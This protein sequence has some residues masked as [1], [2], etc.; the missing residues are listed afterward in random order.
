MS[1]ELELKLL[2]E[3][4]LLREE[5]NKLKGIT[6]S[7]IPHYQYSKLNFKILE[8]IIDIKQNFLNETKFND[9]FNTKHE[10]KE[11]DI[12]FLDKL[13]NKNKLLLDNY[14][15]E[16]LKANFIIPLLNKVDFLLID[17]EIRAFYEEKLFYETDKFTLGG[18]TDFLVSKGLKY[19]KKPYFFIQEFT[20]TPKPPL[21]EKGEGTY[22]NRSDS[23]MKND[24]P[25]PQ[26]LAEMVSAI[27]LNSW[28]SIKGAY[29]IGANWNFVI[30]EKVNKNKYQYFIS[31]KFDSMK[32]EDLVNIYQYLISI[33]KEIIDLDS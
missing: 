5:N 33:K 31:S 25:E 4:K 13:I 30:L 10:V 7:K 3:I 26:L 6:E 22:I 23:L 19:A 27:E 18:T 24:D 1:E 9:W 32:I 29:I 17:K 8:S 21:P 11:N 14:S 15:E 20:P 28:N 2:R 12:D 16:D